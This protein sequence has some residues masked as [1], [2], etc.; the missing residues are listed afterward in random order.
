MVIYHRW[1]VL[2]VVHPLA[3]EVPR[4]ISYYKNTEGPKIIKRSHVTQAT[5]FGYFLFEARTGHQLY[6]STQF[7][8]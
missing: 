4:F 7:E 1:L 8:V 3:S 2:A 6:L 5:R